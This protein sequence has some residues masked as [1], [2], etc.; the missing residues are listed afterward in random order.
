MSVTVIIPA[1]N[2]EKRISS[3]L[4]EYLEYFPDTVR[5][6]VVLNGCHDNTQDV[7]DFWQ[8]KYPDRVDYVVLDK[9]GKGWAV[10]KGFEKVQDEI[11]GFVDADNS[12]TAPEFDK[13]LK[14]IE[15]CDV[16]IGSRYTPGASVIHR[17]S[18]LRKL[19]GRLFHI[20]VRVITF[21]PFY[22]TQCGAKVFHKRVIE[23]ILPELRV[24]NMALSLIHI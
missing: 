7:V 20:I 3:A 14:K 9:S 22:D 15:I 8:K 10:K 23:K 24:N 18:W 16:A 11:I 13:I 4:S 17:V 6:F 1:Y 19:A 5:F 2:E 12:T 21:L